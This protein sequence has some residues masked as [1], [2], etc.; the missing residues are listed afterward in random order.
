MSSAR[1]KFLRFKSERFT[2]EETED[3]ISQFILDT[4]PIG[5][6]YTEE[7]GGFK[8]FSRMVIRGF[9][10]YCKRDAEY[11]LIVAVSFPGENWSAAIIQR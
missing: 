4:E 6:T 3:F 8:G 9:R 10:V 5:Q 1:E 2:S 7:F 11:I